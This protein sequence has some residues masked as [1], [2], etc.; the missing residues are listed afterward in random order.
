M[1]ILLVDDSGTVVGM[2]RALLEQLGHTVESASDGVGG[3]EMVASFE[4]DVVL[5]DLKMPRMNGL[6]VVRAIRDRSVTLPVIIFT[7]EADIP[8]AVEAMRLGAFSYVVK[9]VAVD[10]LM[11]EIESAYA[12]RNRLE[13]ARALERERELKDS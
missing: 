11:A 9:G 12:H 10:R 13:R 3:L 5:C 7:D 8:Q 2:M 4:P 1:R 6:D